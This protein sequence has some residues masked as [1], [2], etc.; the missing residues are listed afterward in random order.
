MD[1]EDGDDDDE[2]EEEEEAEAEAEAEDEE[3]GGRVCDGVARNRR[4]MTEVR[5]SCEARRSD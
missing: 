2:E 1:E 5:E 3:M 4:W